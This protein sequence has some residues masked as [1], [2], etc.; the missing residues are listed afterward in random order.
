MVSE[1]TH[2]TLFPLSCVE[3]V[4]IVLNVWLR[5]RMEW[6]A[7]GLFVPRFLSGLCSSGVDCIRVILSMSDGLSALSLTAGS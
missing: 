5:C 7:A 1:V 4:G 2:V 6:H 3:Q